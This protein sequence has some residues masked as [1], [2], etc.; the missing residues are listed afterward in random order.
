MITCKCIYVVFAKNHILQML[1][2][3]GHFIKHVLFVEKDH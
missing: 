2:L 3:M 1:N